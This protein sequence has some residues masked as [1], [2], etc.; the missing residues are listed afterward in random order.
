MHCR[1][2]MC[3]GGCGVQW[4]VNKAKAKKG[5]CISLED[6]HPDGQKEAEAFNNDGVMLCSMCANELSRGTD[7]SN[8]YD[9][10]R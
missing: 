3:G 6:I 4:V 9:V 5:Y 7:K 2:G 10:L 1:K 8:G